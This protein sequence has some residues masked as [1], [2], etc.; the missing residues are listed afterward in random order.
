[1][2][3]D[4]SR[5]LFYREL[6]KDIVTE[7]VA[8]VCAK[9]ED[10]NIEALIHNLTQQTI[11]LKKIIVV[12][13]G[14]TDET[15]SILKRLKEE[16]IQLEVVTLKD[17]GFSAV[18]TPFLGQ[19]WNA[20][21]EKIDRENTDFVFVCGAD[22]QYPLDYVER[23]LENLYDDKIGVISG[24]IPSEHTSKDHARGGGRL[25]RSVIL[26]HMNYRYPFIYGWESYVC[27]VA[28]YLGFS[29]THDPSVIYSSRKSGI[30][31]NNSYYMSQGIGMKELGYHPLVL[32]RRAV[33]F[34]LR[35]RRPSAGLNMLMGFL[36]TKTPKNAN[37]YRSFLYKHQMR[38]IASQIK[39]LFPF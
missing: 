38:E 20:G 16:I 2:V 15:A 12:D 17:R 33:L 6:G 39:K 22:N 25:I 19:T 9:N 5:N 27:T 26:E 3:I 37:K 4:Y 35:T 34:V 8:L 14:S 7:I 24:L 32:V 18:G 30:L 1:M 28:R 13:D 23:L 11:Y 29:I 21:F 36:R 31:S 10:D